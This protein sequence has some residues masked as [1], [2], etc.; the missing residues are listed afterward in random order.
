[1]V[2]VRGTPVAIDLIDPR[3]MHVLR[4]ASGTDEVGRALVHLLGNGDCF[5]DVGANHAAYAAFASSR[6]EATELARVGLP[7]FAD[8]PQLEV[9]GLDP[10]QAVS[11]AYGAEATK[12]SVTGVPGGFS[13]VKRPGT[14]AAPKVVTG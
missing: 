9:I 7:F 5:L 6:S 4:E 2:E 8:D 3:V 10:P 11:V 13:V 12:F 14:A 1:M